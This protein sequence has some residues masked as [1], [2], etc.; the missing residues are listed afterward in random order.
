MV[1]G[2]PIDHSKYIILIGL[3]D[4]MM[5]KKAK[6][7]DAFAHCFVAFQHGRFL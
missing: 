3:G 1:F 5:K 6:P 7:G 2:A 4:I